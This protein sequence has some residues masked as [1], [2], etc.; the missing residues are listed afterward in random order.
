MGLPIT[1]I[2]KRLSKHRLTLYRE[3]NRNSEPEGYF[4][5]TAQLKTEERAK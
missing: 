1:D 4:P 3:L 2:A 5:K